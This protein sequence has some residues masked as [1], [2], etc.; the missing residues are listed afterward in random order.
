[1]TKARMIVL[2]ILALLTVAVG[3]LAIASA[4]ADEGGIAAAPTGALAS[5]AQQEPTAHSISPEPTPPLSPAAPPTA[6]VQETASPSPAPLATATP[7]TTPTPTLTPTPTPTVTPTPASTAKVS[8]AAGSLKG[9]IIGVDPGHQAKANRDQE[10]SSPG[11]SETKNKV[12]SGTSGVYTGVREHEVNLAVG[13]KLQKL[14]KDAG[15]TVVMTRTTAD[16]DISNVE[17]AQLFNEKK[18]D[19]GVRLHCNGSTDNSVT[20]AFML[21]PKDKSYPYYSENV[22]AAKLILEEYGKATGIGIKK[23]IT[24]RADQTGFNW[25]ERPIVNIEMGH[26]TNKEE[27]SKLTSSDFQDKMAIGIF[28]GIMRYFSE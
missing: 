4:G 27:D 18:V 16:V 14:L 21:V 1:M 7:T 19:L 17:R 12:S 6:A 22:K 25:C 23:G 11:S 5:P 2:C 28:N 3:V 24:Y 13:L 26:M 8:A 10:P 9:I 20:G 15:A